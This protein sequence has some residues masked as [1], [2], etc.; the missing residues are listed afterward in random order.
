[1][2]FAVIYSVVKDAATNYKKIYLSFSIQYFKDFKYRRQGFNT[3]L[4]IF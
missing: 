2:R 4:E 3:P 1:M